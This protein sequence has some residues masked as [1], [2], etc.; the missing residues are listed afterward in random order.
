MH[1]LETCFT[2]KCVTWHTTLHLHYTPICLLKSFRLRI[3][4]MAPLPYNGSVSL[5]L[6]AGQVALRLLVPLHSAPRKQFLAQLRITKAIGRYS[7]WLVLPRNSVV[8]PLRE[9]L[10]FTWLIVKCVSWDMEDSST[11]KWRKRRRI[12]QQSSRV[13]VTSS[14]YVTISLSLSL[15]VSLCIRLACVPL[16]FMVGAMFLLAP[17]AYGSPP[18]WDHEEWWHLLATWCMHSLGN[19]SVESMISVSLE[20]SIPL[21]CRCLVSLSWSSFIEHHTC[22]FQKAGLRVLFCHSTNPDY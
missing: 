4:W 20:L 11:L 21:Q 2:Q 3:A 19:M 8:L 10:E 13:A 7:K 15:I 5:C 9:R 6:C 12:R 18:C 14:G 16:L 17:R 22:V 1:F